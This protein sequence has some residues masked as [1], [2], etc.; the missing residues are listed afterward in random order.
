MPIRP[1]AFALVAVLL[2]GLTIATP[3][4]LGGE[5]PTPSN[6]PVATTTPTA[7]PTPVVV[8][9]VGG[10]GLVFETTSSLT[11]LIHDNATSTAGFILLD[12]PCTHVSKE[13]F[14]HR[15]LTST[16]CRSATPPGSQPSILFPPALRTAPTA[17]P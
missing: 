14:S 7:T 16:R 3:A 17:P 9:Q 11:D 5:A 8:K 2:A 13:S 15:P 4:A 1:P 12:K 6:P 10:D